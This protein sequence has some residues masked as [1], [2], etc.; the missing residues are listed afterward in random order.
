MQDKNLVERKF[1]DLFSAKHNLDYNFDLNQLKHK[2]KKIVQT[3]RD[4]GIFGARCLDIG[5]GTGRWIQFLRSEGASCIGAVDISA[6]SLKRCEPFVNKSYKANLEKDPL[7]FEAGSMDIIIS[8]EVLEHLCD[9]S[10]YINEIIRVASD[11]ALIIM[12]LPNIVSLISRLRMLIGLMPVA[13]ASDP[14]HVSFYRQKDIKQL[15]QLYNLNP[16]FIPTS[17]S[18]N[19]RA[20]KSKFSIPSNKLLCSFDDSLLFSLRINKE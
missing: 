8:F 2:D 6:E 7:K 13:I 5:P 9:P 20:T 14:T 11:D 3:L 16:Q 10:N 15:F 1:D 4:K 18:L 12:S 19:P 17:I